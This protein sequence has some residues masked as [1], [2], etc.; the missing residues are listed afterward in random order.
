MALNNS[1]SS[2]SSNNLSNTPNNNNN[3]SENVKQGNLVVRMDEDSATKLQALFDTV[4][5]PSEQN[6]PLQIPLRMRKLPNS[7]FNPPSTGSKSPSVSHSRENSID[8]AFGSG[9]T[10]VYAPG[11]GGGATGAANSVLT[12][13]L[14][15]SHSRAHSSPATLEQTHAA[16]LKS[17]AAAAGATAASAT[18]AQNTQT[19]PQTPLKAVHAS[20][21]SYDVISAIQLQDELGDLPPGWEQARTAEGQIYY[22]NHNTRTTQWEDPRKQLAAHQ[23]LVS[24]QSADSLLRSQPP[25]QQQ[26]PIQQNSG[27]P[28]TK[29]SSATSVSSDPLLGPL[30]DGW[31]QAVTSAGET[32]FINHINRTTSWFDPRIPEHFQR[33]EMSRNAGGWLNIQNLQKER[34][35]LKQRQQEIQHQTMGLQMDPFLP[36]VTDHSRQESSDSGLSLTSNHYS[37]PQNSDFMS[38]DDSMDCI[39]ESGTLE[40]STL[41][42]T[43]DLVPSLQLGEG[44]NNDILDD[45]HS[46]MDSEVKTDSL[47]W[48]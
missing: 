44:F 20:Q 43:D 24:H 35:Y 12:Q 4:L 17:A 13:R 18:A 37:M 25:Q 38:I 6:R 32:Y 30:P 46:L 41:E 8:S 39:S 23:A 11:G 21:R 36:G 26:P 22:L 15:I 47:T 34:E 16:S 14:S 10:I 28:V 7:F 2:G 27:N 5:K 29:L 19:Q 1:S 33:S 9:T 45:V 42:N 48:I 3:E 40:T 31:E